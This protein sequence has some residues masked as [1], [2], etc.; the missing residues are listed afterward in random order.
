[1]NVSFTAEFLYTHRGDD[2]NEILPND[3]GEIG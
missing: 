1:M 2:G 3:S